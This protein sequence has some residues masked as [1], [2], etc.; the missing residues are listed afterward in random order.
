M[1]YEPLPVNFRKSPEALATYSYFDSI[2]GAAF[3]KF[4]LLGTLDSVGPKY[5]LTIDNTIASDNDNQLDASGAIDLDFDIDVEVPFTVAA[6]TAIVSQPSQNAGGAPII[7]YTIYHVAAD[8]TETSIGAV[9]TPTLSNLDRKTLQISL[10]RTRFKK[11][12]KLRLN[13]NASSAIST[14]WDPTG[15]IS[16]TESTSNRQTTSQ[17]YLLLPVEI[18]V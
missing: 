8:T 6:R 16:I 7:T 15:G 12:E 3:I 13:V 10:T 11:G 5:H 1:E 14:W 17:A 18:P 4:Y 2:I 9:T